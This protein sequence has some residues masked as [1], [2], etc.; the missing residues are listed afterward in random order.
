M[1]EK[2][3][4]IRPIQQIHCEDLFLTQ[5]FMAVAERFAHLPGTVLL[6]SGGDLD[7]AGYHILGIHPWLD[8]S[9]RHQNLNLRMSG[10]EYALNQDPFSLLKEILGAFRLSPGISPR[11]PPMQCGL[12]G[13]LA[14]DLKDCIEDLPRTSVDRSG[15]PHIQL[16]GHSI[17]LVHDKVKN[18]TKLFLPE[19]EGDEEGLI[20]Q[21]LAGF[22]SAINAD[23]HPPD[24]PEKGAGKPES[25][26]RKET[27]LETLIKIIEYIAAGDVYQVN[28]SQK[29]SA[30]FSG[31]P[32]AL[33]K[34]YYEAN[35]APFFAYIH[36]GDH[37]IISTSPERFLIQNGRQIETRPIKGTRPRGKTPD[38]DLRLQEELSN[39]QKD[40]AELSMIVDLQRNDIGKV[41]QGGSV[42]V[43]EH[44]RVEAY[45][46]VYHLVSV[47]KGTL[48]PRYD[49]T[50]VIRAT[51]PGGSITG[52]PKIRAMEIID[53]LE[54][55]RRHVYTG[56]IGYISFHDTMDLSIAIRTAVIHNGKLSFSVGGGIVFDS[57]PEEEYQETLHKGRT[58]MSAFTDSE[59]PN[60]RRPETMWFNGRMVPAQSAAVPVWDPGFQYGFGFF[61]TIRADHGKIRD[62]P[63]HL[64]RFN[65]TWKTLF[66]DPEPDLTWEVILA[67]VLEENG[68]DKGSAA[69]KIMATKGTQ[70]IAPYNHSLIVSAR[71]YVHRLEGKKDQGIHLV[72]YPHPRQSPLAAHKTLNYLYYHL[73]GKWAV[74]KGMDEALILNSDGTLSETN[75]ASLILIRHNSAILP[76]S[77]HVLPGTMQKCVTDILEQWNYEIALEPL[78]P[79]QMFSF[80][81][82]LLTNALMGAVP[83]LSIDGKSL[84]PPSDLWK[85]INRVLFE[86][87]PYRF[88]R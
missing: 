62:L 60:P 56:S 14:Y 82:I 69:L 84:S 27:Y 55:D 19:F 81:E 70:D 51:F 18:T 54:P 4:R 28:L 44:K 57:D 48:A 80:D 13:Y 58:L 46:N 65:Q 11:D 37:Q 23:F 76:K 39:S 25:N 2:L 53:E 85:R 52:C 35:P 15:L 38:E 88:S 8:F 1:M 10:R 47:V 72:T 6:M 66:T 49:S 33:F 16:Y 64:Q 43:A 17:V 74:Q 31:N 3:P 79:E 59:K 78:L 12:M 61:E 77:T 71:P 68:L 34:S 20:A 29:F 73:A 30:D 32:F 26:F 87:G 36:A 86:D 7:C 21:R 67:K 22:L 45:Q 24:F 50:D 75:T 41:C 40:D 63:N 42:H 9:G 5:P 83:A